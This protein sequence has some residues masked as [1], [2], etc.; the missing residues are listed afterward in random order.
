MNVLL[1]CLA[2]PRMQGDP[3]KH[4]GSFERFICMVK[5]AL[6]ERPRFL[7]QPWY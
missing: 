2:P 7:G 5:V 1:P 3:E 4:V 6:K